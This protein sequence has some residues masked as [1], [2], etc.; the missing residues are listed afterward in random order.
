MS[1]P[2]RISQMTAFIKSEAEEKAK[3][4]DSQTKE[5]FAIEK[6]NRVE[7]EKKRLRA[8][9]DLKKKAV[10]VEKQI[11]HSNAIKTARLEILKMKEETVLHIK[12]EAIEA[13]KKTEKDGKRYTEFLINC[14]L[15]GL[16]TL[17]EKEVK[18]YCREADYKFLVDSSKSIS[19][20][21][22][23]MKGLETKLLVQDK[24]FLQSSGGVLVSALNDRIKV[25][26]TIEERVEL[27]FHALI[28]DLRNMMFPIQEQL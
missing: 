23:S 21:F 16:I 8:E 10:E 2:D 12:D 17:E 3:E 24:S 5:D 4:I 9:Y 20:K 19:E 28:P 14:V 6:Q 26:N 18:V 25:N 13:V 7:E 22:K 15:Q 1:K 27:C 11:K